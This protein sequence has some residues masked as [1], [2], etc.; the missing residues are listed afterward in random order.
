MQYKSFPRQHVHFDMSEHPIVSKEKIKLQVPLYFSAFI[1]RIDS[2][3]CSN[4]QLHKAQQSKRETNQV[5]ELLDEYFLFKTNQ[6]IG[7]IVS[8]FFFLN[9]EQKKS[10]VNN[11]DRK[12]K[13][14]GLETEI[15]PDIAAELILLYF[16]KAE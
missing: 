7:S 8:S 13:P 2:S 5:Q 6:S 15:C 11:F 1:C 16:V 4:R 12:E 9:H 14:K 10:L 3:S